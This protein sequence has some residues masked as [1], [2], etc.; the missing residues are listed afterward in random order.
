MKTVLVRV[1]RDTIV[2]Q[3]LRVQLKEDVHLVTIVL[4][5][6]V[7]QFHVNEVITVYMVLL[8]QQNAL[9]EPI[10]I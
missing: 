3:A 10:I 2:L 5:R 8:D 4:K 6:H 9:L 7:I 1:E